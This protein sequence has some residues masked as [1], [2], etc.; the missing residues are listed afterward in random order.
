MRRRW[1]SNTYHSSPRCALLKR[2]FQC[3][4][5]TTASSE[6]CEIRIRSTV[7]CESRFSTHHTHFLAM[8]SAER[9]GTSGNPGGK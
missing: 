8:V 4:H 6:S 9:H 7:H 2:R 3:V 1:G 5:S